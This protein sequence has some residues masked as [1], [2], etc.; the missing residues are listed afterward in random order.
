ML[1]VFAILSSKANPK[2]SLTL[3]LGGISAGLS[4]GDLVFLVKMGNGG[5]RINFFLPVFLLAM[6]RSFHSYSCVALSR[7]L[8]GLSQ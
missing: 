8:G 3:I 4:N 1:Y 2:I 6:I 7:A 5:L